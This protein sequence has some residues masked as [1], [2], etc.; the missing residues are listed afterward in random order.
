MDILVYNKMKQKYGRRLQKILEPLEPVNRL[1]LCESV[2]GLS[3]RLRHVVQVPAVA[4]LNAGSR[5]ELDALVA[6]ADLLCDV[7]IILIL[8]DRKMETTAAGHRLHPRY[9]TYADSD[10]SEISAVLGKM[11]GRVNPTIT[12]DPKT[13]M[14]AVRA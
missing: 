9:L 6:L 1:E 2:D 10:F 12:A 11:I 3:F 14:G 8:P 5:R 4:V 7:R 13:A